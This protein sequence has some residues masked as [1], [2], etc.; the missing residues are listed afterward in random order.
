VPAARPVVA[1][2]ISGGEQ[3]GCRAGASVP[4]SSADRAW[5]ATALPVYRWGALWRS[6][7]GVREMTY[8]RGLPV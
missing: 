4:P 1:Q 6:I 2:A 7:I 5:P 8:R 3:S